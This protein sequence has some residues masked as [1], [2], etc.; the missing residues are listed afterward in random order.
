MYVVNPD[1]LDPK[2]PLYDPSYKPKVYVPF[3]PANPWNDPTSEHWAVSKAI[4][5]ESVNLGPDLPLTVKAGAYTSPATVYRYTYPRAGTYKAVF[6]GS[7]NSVDGSISAT[8]EV[9]VTITP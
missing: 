1:K 7:N 2:N 5:V 8:K 3:N 9:T 4:N 6:T